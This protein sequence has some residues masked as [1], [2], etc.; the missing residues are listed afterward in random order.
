MA[1]G[2]VKPSSL[3]KEGML[4]FNTP[5]RVFHEFTPKSNLAALNKFFEKYH[6]AVITDPESLK[7]KH[8][9]TKMDLLTYLINNK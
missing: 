8:V 4:V 6:S 5:G 2:A 9:A 7:V 1:S 3:V